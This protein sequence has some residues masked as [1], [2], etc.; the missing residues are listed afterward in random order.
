M[1]CSNWTEWVDFL[2][3]RVGRTLLVDGGKALSAFGA[4]S[5]WIFLTA[6]LPAGDPCIVLNLFLSAVDRPVLDVLGASL[7]RRVDVGFE[8]GVVLGR[9]VVGLLTDVL[10]GAGL[11]VPALSVDVL[12]AVVVLLTGAG[13]PGRVGAGLVTG[14]DEAVRSVE[15][16][17]TDMRLGF[18]AMPP[19][20]R[21]DS[22]SVALLPTVATEPVNLCVAGTVPGAAGLRTV[23]VVVVVGLVGGLLRLEA[24]EVVFLVA[25]AAVGFVNLS[26]REEGGRVF[27]VV[28][29]GFV[30]AFLTVLGVPAA[31]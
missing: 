27:V 21:L 29:V 18:A 1:R 2:V 19:P 15:E 9:A 26:V 3:P 28:A 12:V 4:C 14:L 5:S 23:E 20:S 8:T 6:G 16:G 25:D 13:A 31:A 10:G 17:A 30:A 11:L 22:S 7:G 24:A